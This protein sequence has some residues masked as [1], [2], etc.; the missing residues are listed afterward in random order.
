MP[1]GPELR[2]S[3]DV[4]RHVLLGKSIVRLMTT[5]S[6]RYSN[7]RPEGLDGVIA[8]MPLKVESIDVKGKFMWWTLT[9][10]NRTWYMWCTYGMSGQWSQTSSPH[11]AFIAE[12]NGSGDIASADQQKLFFNDQR[13]FGTIKFTYD[14]KKHEK[15]LTSLGPD[16]LNDPP[17]D[18]EIF[19]KRIL[20]KPQRTICEAL[21]D[22]S[23]ISGC[24]NYL[25]AEALYRSKISPHTIVTDLSAREIFK[26]QHELSS[27]ARESYAD[28]G[29]SIRTYRTV[30]GDK[31][32]AQF[33]FRVYGLKQCPE[34]HQVRREET[35]DGR[36]SWWC[37]QCQKS[38]G[39]RFLPLLD[40]A[41]FGIFSTLMLIV[42]AKITTVIAAMNA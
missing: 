30:T 20:L 38:D 10:K 37:P 11:V 12:F 6:G 9:G 21:M 33:Q 8:D 26:L 28:H 2:H 31:G 5:T 35:K 16:I 3:R 36:T 4:L 24:G 29:A 18:P 14:Q 22:Q 27:A 40:G 34:G 39:G 42:A 1:E 7:K 32:Q 13:R 41:G 23:C 19:V 15:K 17:T 25:K